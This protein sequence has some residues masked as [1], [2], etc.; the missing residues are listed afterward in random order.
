M[1]IRVGVAT[2][3]TGQVDDDWLDLWIDNTRNA[4]TATIV[5]AAVGI[6]RVGSVGVMVAMA[7]GPGSPSV[8]VVSTTMGWVH[9]IGSVCFMWARAVV[10]VVICAP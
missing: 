9:G 1:R 10:G 7:S 4:G 5:V 2:M 6:I 3:A 8:W